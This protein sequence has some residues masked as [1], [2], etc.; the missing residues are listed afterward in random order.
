M[1]GFDAE[2]KSDLCPIVPRALSVAAFTLYYAIG[3]NWVLLAIGHVT[4]I[5][6]DLYPEHFH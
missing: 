6:T 2:G 5:I 4:T 3:K 1:L